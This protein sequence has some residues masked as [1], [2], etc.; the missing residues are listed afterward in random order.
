MPSNNED[1]EEQQQQQY[2]NVN[3]EQNLLNTI[4]SNSYGIETILKSGEVL[5]LPSYWFHYIIGLQKNSQC[6]V[7]LHN[8]NTSNNGEDEID[9]EEDEGN[10]NENENSEFGGRIDVSSERC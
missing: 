6:N 8:Q 4:S 5:F 2:N 7:R 10:E 3:I 9:D 1:E